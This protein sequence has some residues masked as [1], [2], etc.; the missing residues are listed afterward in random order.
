MCTMPDSW[1]RM[2]AD[3]RSMFKRRGPAANDAEG[4]GWMEE[5]VDVAELFVVEGDCADA[6]GAVD[7]VLYERHAGALFDEAIHEVET[8][9]H[10]LHPQVSVG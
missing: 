8:V 3:A 4:S 7:L 2:P 5:D 6:A 9:L 10:M 1:R